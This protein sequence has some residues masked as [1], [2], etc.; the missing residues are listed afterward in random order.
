[1]FRMHIDEQ[2]IGAYRTRDEAWVALM[3]YQRNVSTIEFDAFCT[4]LDERTGKTYH[5]C[6]RSGFL[7]ETQSCACDSACAC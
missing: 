1:M 3:H 2:Y 5:L 7:Q 4:L 6:H